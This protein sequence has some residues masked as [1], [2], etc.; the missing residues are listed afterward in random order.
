M[1]SYRQYCGLAKA[2][3]VIGD[4]WTLLIVRE[5]L[6]RERCRYSDL[7]DGLPGI[8]TNLLAERLRDLEQAGVLSREEAPPPVAATLYQLTSRGKELE[9]VIHQI[10]RWGGPLAAERRRGDAFRSHWMALPIRLHLADR[11]PDRPPIAIQLHCGEEPMVIE[12]EKGQVR[13]RLGVAADPDA[14]LTGKPDVVV[15]VLTGR[16]ALSAARAAGLKFEGRVEALRRVVPPPAA[17]S[18]D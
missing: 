2:L 18:L 17:R 10:G 8:A 6:I 7:R 12:V 1:R 4:R 9:A 11:T 15:A 13:P 14:T 3:D 16:L 5:L